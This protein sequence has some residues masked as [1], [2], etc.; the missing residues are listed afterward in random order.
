LILLYLHVFN[1]FDESDSVRISQ[2]CLPKKLEWW[3]YYDIQE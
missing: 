2:Q 1:D 3:G